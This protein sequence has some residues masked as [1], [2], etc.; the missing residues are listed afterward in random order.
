MDSGAVVAGDGGVIAI[1][2][3]SMYS[4]T[5]L[6]LKNAETRTKNA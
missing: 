5:S 2:C 1:S 6:S 3:M 4:R